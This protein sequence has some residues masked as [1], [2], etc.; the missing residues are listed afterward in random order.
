MKNSGDKKM[1]RQ[2]EGWKNKIKPCGDLDGGFD[3]IVEENLNSGKEKMKN[4]WN[5]NLFIKNKL[6]KKGLITLRK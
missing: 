3:K 4:T 6:Q 2:N 5:Q 1:M